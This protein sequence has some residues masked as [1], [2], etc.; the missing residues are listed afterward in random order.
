MKLF[1]LPGSALEGV[2]AAQS[3]QK[4]KCP[5][6]VQSARLADLLTGLVGSTEC[7]EVR[8]VHVLEVIYLP[9]RH[10]EAVGVDPL[11][12]WAFALEHRHL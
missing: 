7:A 2:S 3:L 10:A 4:A 1:K 11:A 6:R 8:S 12:T 9:L 5:V